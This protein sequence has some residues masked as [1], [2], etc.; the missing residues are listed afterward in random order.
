MPVAAGG[1]RWN[2]GGA[3]MSA[4]SFVSRVQGL[5][6]SW[7]ERRQVEGIAGAHDFASQFQLLQTLHRWAE[8]AVDEIR[9]VYG[10]GIPV[11][12]TPC[13]E[14]PAFGRSDE[15]GFSVVAG[16]RYGVTFSLQRRQRANAPSWMIGATVA[17]HGS[18]GNAVAAGPERRNG[19]WTRTRVEDLLLSVL[20]A[21][22]RSLAE[23][24]APLAETL[25]PGGAQLGEG[26]TD[27]QRRIGG[28]FAGEAA[29]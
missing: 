1:N 20:G 3:G 28:E 4:E 10:D 23:A 2:E 14:T 27:G 19:R 13:P 21:H 11:S 17:A 18:G 12:V 25:T 5:R 15:A 22:E 24:E 7:V 6:D 29:E 8:H 9:S 26:L 16:Q